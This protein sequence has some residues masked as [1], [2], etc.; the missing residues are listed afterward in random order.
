MR[1]S[2]H[3]RY[4]SCPR[5]AYNLVEEANGNQVIKYN[6]FNRILETNSDMLQLAFWKSL[7]PEELQLLG[8]MKQKKDT[9]LK[10]HAAG[11]LVPESGPGEQGHW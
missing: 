5:E 6:L 3:N 11:R 7:L 8:G 10:P 9:E 1:N 4:R 2:E